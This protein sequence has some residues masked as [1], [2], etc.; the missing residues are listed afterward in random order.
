MSENSYKTK[1]STFNEKIVHYLKLPF[2]G[3]LWVISTET[4]KETLN[5]KRFYLQ[6]F[7]FSIP[8]LF[9]L[10]GLGSTPVTTGS[11]EAIYRAH[12]ELI[13]VFNSLWLIWTG[14]IFVFLLASDAIS[15][16]VERDT[17][18]TLRTKPI[19]D[20]DIVYG[21]FLGFS[22]LILVLILP[23]STIAYYGRMVQ[24]GASSHILWSS[25]DE[26]LG[27]III[28]WLTLSAYIALALVFSALFSK[29]LH[30]IMAGIMAI[31]GTEI[32]IGGTGLAGLDEYL[33]NYISRNLLK[34]V[35]YGSTKLEEYDGT[36]W[37]SLLVLL[38]INLSLLVIC[39]QVLKRKE[40]P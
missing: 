37:I 13:G 28:A 14:E 20:Y 11:A 12:S 8:V 2:R 29:S 27:A 16:E 22:L 4:F 18:K 24:Y 5:N 17:L 23:L 6:A 25:L 19:Y 33:P 34:E 40:L 9:L 3:P 15:G 38:F 21:K 31:F 35:L 1:L 32:L 36:W 10:F 39:H 30:S 7:V 26:L